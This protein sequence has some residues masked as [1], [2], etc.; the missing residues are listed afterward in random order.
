MNRV[1]VNFS[2][3]EKFTS[4]W[5]GLGIKDVSLQVASAFKIKCFAWQLFISAKIKLL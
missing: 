3:Y 1:T 5:N 2:F 4:I